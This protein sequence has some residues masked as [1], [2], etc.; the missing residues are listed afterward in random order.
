VELE[1]REKASRATTTT[2][3]FNQSQQETGGVQVA[4]NR[5]DISTI[6]DTEQ[7]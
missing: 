1:R 4:D 2:Q 5:F 6:P 7:I 3:T